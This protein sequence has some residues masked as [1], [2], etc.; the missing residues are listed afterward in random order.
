MLRSAKSPLVDL[1][2]HPRP[3]LSRLESQWVLR[4]NASAEQVRNDLQRFVDQNDRLFVAVCTG[5]AAWVNVLI[6][7]NRLVSELAA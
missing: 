7:N 3:Q 5:E 4:N 6:D 1:P 2:S